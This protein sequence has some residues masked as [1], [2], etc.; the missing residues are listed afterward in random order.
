ME[1]CKGLVTGGL[2]SQLTAGEQRSDLWL[3]WN[4]LIRTGGVG[5]SAA[6]EQFAQGHAVLTEAAD[7]DTATARL[8]EFARECGLNRSG[9]Q[10]TGF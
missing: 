9:M 5:H 3:A 7:A 8:D 1:Y 10:V 2:S 6:P 4:Y